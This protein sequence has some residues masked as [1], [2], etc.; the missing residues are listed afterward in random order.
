MPVRRH[1]AVRKLIHTQPIGPWFLKAHDSW[2]NFYLPRISERK[3][4]PARQAF[5]ANPPRLSPV[6]SRVLEE[7]RTTGMGCAP[8][9]E[10]L[11]GPSL[12]KGVR[13][14]ICAWTESPEHAARARAYCEGGYRE[15]RGKP[16]EIKKHPH[17]TWL[18][19]D[20]LYIRFGLQREILGIVNSY[21]GLLAKLTHVDAWHNLSLNLDIPRLES[22]NW[23]RDPEDTKLVKVFLYLTDVDTG[24]GAMEYVLRSR[25]GEKYGEV[26]PQRVPYGSRIPDQQ[27][28]QRVAPKDRAICAFPSGTCV[29]VDTV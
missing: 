18:A 11:D 29:F 6:Q 2:L 3:N 26:Y 12:W 28:E 23:H 4:F 7:L 5:E 24:S 1:P 10:L 15:T 19:P 9:T 22:Q 8:V 13:E 20:H 14:D 27:I 21:F 25:P 16:Y 17:G